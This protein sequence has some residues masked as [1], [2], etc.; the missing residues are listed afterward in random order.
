MKAKANGSKLQ[1]GSWEILLVHLALL[2]P[3]IAIFVASFIISPE[4]LESPSGLS[5]L[6]LP[7]CKYKVLTEKPCFTCGLTRGFCAISHGAPQQARQFNQLSLWF[8]SLFVLLT[9]MLSVSMVANWLALKKNKK[10]KR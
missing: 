9:F 7:E 10:I 3:L 5:K 2:L 8:Y 1:F 4:K 6:V